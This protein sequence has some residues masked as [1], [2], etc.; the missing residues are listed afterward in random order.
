MKRTKERIE[1]EI[2]ELKEKLAS[3]EK[4]LQAFDSKVSVEWD[5]AC[6]RRQHGKPYLAIITKGENGKK[7]NYDFLITVDEWSNKGRYVKSSYQGE[8]TL[9]TILRGRTGS[10]WKNDYTCF[11]IVNPEGLE[12]IDEHTALQKLGIL[13]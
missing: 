7:Y 5:G 11:Y 1:K 9:G 3:L 2:S 13:K 10:S 4:E 12:T 6:D 8:L